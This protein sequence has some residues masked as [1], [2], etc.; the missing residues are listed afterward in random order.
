[1]VKD[2]GGFLTE[3]LYV[4][5]KPGGWFRPGE[6][7]KVIDLVWLTPDGGDPRLC[8]HL[9]YEDGVED[10]MVLDF[11]A[12]EMRRETEHRELG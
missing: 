12:F 8:L 6:W 10:F 1:M 2:F 3:D 5:N 11:N 7:A 4:A 9:L